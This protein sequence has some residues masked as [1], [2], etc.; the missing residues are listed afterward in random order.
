MQDYAEVV[1]GKCIIRSAPGEGTEVMALL[2]L[3]GPGA[4]HSEKA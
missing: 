4:E 2:P 1:G 3:S